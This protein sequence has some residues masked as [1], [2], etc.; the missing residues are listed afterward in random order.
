MSADMITNRH[1]F[2][3]Q[4]VMIATGPI[5]LVMW[6]TG[7]IFFAGFIPVP[8]PRDSAEQVVRHFSEHSNAIRVGLWLTLFGSGLLVPYAAAISSQLR[9]IEG[10]RSPL[11]QCQF[12]C[13]VALSIEFIVP[14]MVW[15]TA[16]YRPQETDPGLIRTLHDMAWLMFVVVVCSVIPQLLCIGYAIFIDDREEPVFP[17]W[18]AYLNLWVA[19]LLVPA[20]LVA[21]FKSGPFAWNGVFGFYVPL[22]AFCIW[23]FAMTYLLLKATAKEEADFSAADSPKADSLP[24]H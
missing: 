16:A 4:R 10:M 19:L 13:A 6:L 5:M 23:L 18:A 15:M 3:V 14:V 20:G 9:R 11:S 12:G 2:Q 17:R 22:S 1:A 8:D 21:F 24:A 7:F